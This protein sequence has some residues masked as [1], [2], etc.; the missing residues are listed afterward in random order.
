MSKHVNK[1][2]VSHSGRGK[3]YVSHNDKV[4]S[5][6]MWN[7]ILDTVLH[8]DKDGVCC[9]CGKPYHDYGANAMP[10]VNGRCCIECDSRF[11]L[12]SR[13]Q[14]LKEKGVHYASIKEGIFTKEAIREIYETHW[15]K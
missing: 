15:D 5:K 8:N 13:L 9:I 2:R 3:S 7:E 1:N 11:V 4:V 10:L 6:K 12:P 14:L